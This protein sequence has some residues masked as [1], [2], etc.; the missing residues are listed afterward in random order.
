MHSRDNFSSTGVSFPF[1]QRRSRWEW[2]PD[3][4]D[5]IKKRKFD[6]VG[7]IKTCGRWADIADDIKKRKF[8]I[9]GDIKT[10]GRWADIADDIKKRKFDIVGDIKTCERWTNRRVRTGLLQYSG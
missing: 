7:D 9:V 6:I 3:I 8:D 4:A 1:R 2:R 10:C 5:D